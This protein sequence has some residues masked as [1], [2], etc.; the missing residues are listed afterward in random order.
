MLGS[1]AYV[2]IEWLYASIRDGRKLAKHRKE[3][4]VRYCYDRDI[5]HSV[6]VGFR[7]KHNLITVPTSITICNH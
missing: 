7:S 1:W 5:S 3:A 2:I 4:L 6:I